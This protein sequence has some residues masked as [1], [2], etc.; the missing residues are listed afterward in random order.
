M[1]VQP[2]VVAAPGG[3]D[4]VGL[5]QDDGPYAPGAQRVRG[6]E[7]AGAAADD[8]DGPVGVGGAAAECVGGVESAMA[9]A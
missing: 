8:V 7:A 4:V 9:G 1:Q 5:F 6:G 3:A 2:V